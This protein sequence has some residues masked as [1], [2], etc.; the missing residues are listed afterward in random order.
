MKLKE[1]EVLEKVANKANLTVLLGDEGLAS[2]VVK[3][4]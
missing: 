2:K 1:L 3:L 4:L